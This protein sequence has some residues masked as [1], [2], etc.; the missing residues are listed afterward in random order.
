MTLMLKARVSQPQECETLPI[1]SYNIGWAS[2]G[3][4]GEYTLVV[5]I[6][7]SWRA[8]QLCYL[9]GP[10]PRLW[11]SPPKHLPRLW[12]ARACEWASAADPKLQS[13]QDTGQ[14]EDIRLGY[15]LGS[16]TDN[17]VEDRGLEPEGWLIEMNIF[18]Y[19]C[20]DKGYTMWYIVTHY[21]FYDKLL[22]FCFWKGGCKDKYK[23]VQRWMRLGCTMWNSQRINKKFF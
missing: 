1:D 19:R 13:L 6:P 16:S 21:S 23:G 11:V 17:A 9:L 18:K 2:Q 8:D 15:P 5:W 4:S 7:E 3:S 10:D 20:V 14:Q 12:T 22:L